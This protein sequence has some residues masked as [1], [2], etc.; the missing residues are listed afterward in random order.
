MFKHDTPVFTDFIPLGV[1]KKSWLQ[2]ALYVADA[3]FAVACPC[4]VRTSNL[5]DQIYNALFVTSMF[6]YVLFSWFG[7]QMW[8]FHNSMRVCNI[9]T[10]R[11]LYS[12][13]LAT[14]VLS[15]HT[16]LPP[17]SDKRWL[18]RQKW[19]EVIV[20]NNVHEETFII[21][22]I[23]YNLVCLYVCLHM[24]KVV[25]V[26][27]IFISS[28]E[29]RPKWPRIFVSV[30]IKK[31]LKNSIRASLTALIMVQYSWP[32]TQTWTT[33]PHVLL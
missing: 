20:E 18:N 12:P 2:A 27:H 22:Y 24:H 7:C 25:C 6:G 26:I 5:Q 8:N 10:H 9:R 21:Y 30:N 15:S 3:R 29:E 33:R 11:I 1:K 19:S 17:S 13:Y 23:S 32:L 28:S 16:F 14:W 31:M 4:A